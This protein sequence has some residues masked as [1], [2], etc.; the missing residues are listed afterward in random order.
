MFMFT[1]MNA[2]NASFVATEVYD[3]GV[4]PMGLGTFMSSKIFL[5]R[6]EKYLQY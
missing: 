6:H 5:E 2:I 3:T 4:R 1:Y